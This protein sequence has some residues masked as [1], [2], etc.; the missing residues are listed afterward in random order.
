MNLTKCYTNK[1]KQSTKLKLSMLCTGEVFKDMD[2][3][4]YIAENVRDCITC[5]VIASDNAKVAI[6]QLRVY[7]STGLANIT[8]ERLNH[9]LL[10]YTNDLAFA[11]QPKV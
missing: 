7:S 5:V 10:I 6:P 3:T 11:P 2:E 8:V 9:K 4:L 1:G